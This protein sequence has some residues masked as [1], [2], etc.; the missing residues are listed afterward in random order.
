MNPPRH[1]LNMATRKS[2]N[3]KLTHDQCRLK[4]CI[5]CV[6]KKKGV[7]PISLKV[8]GF[9]KNHIP[10]LNFENDPRLP[11]GIC[12]KCR[13]NIQDPSKSHLLPERYD[14][15]KFTVQHPTTSSP[16]NESACLV[17]KIGR[18]SA[19]DERKL[20]AMAAAQKVAGANL[21]VC[22]ECL[23]YKAEGVVHDCKLSQL[24]K[25]STS[26]R[27]CTSQNN[28]SKL[29]AKIATSESLANFMKKHG[30]S[31]RQ[32][33]TFQTYMRGTYGTDAVES[34]AQKKL[35]KITHEM[36]EFFEAHDEEF[37]ESDKNTLIL[38]FLDTE[39]AY[40]E[41]TLVMCQFFI[42]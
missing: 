2:G 13:K 25:E 27:P 15:S 12:D 5:L 38:L 39:D 29:E 9:I 24:P 17:C 10:G 37:V 36:D 4:I 26:E 22:P 21:N 33:E 7:G 1:R 32:M 6:D 14:Y 3:E 28:Q 19:I 34:Y 20:V 40:F 35:S 11:N 18:M 23:S 8:R 16:H 41:S 30:Y 42:A 31:L